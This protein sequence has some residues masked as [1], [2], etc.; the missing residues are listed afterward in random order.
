MKGSSGKLRILIKTNLVVSN[1]EAPNAFMSYLAYALGGMIFSIVAII[2]VIGPDS[3]SAASSPLIFLM[4]VLMFDYLNLQVLLTRATLIDRSMLG[5]FPLS[6][7]RSSVL[8]FILML[9]DRSILFYIIPAI[10]VVT[11]LFAK[12]EPAQAL[13][14]IL[15]FGSLYL[16]LSEILF[17]LY[18]VFRAIAERY[19]ARTA[20]QIAVLP[21][22][23][24]L[25]FPGLFQLS[26]K[27]V[28]RIP[29]AAEFV[30]GVRL[31]LVSGFDGGMLEVV[32]LLL[33]AL[34]LGGILL[35]AAFL[36]SRIDPLFHLA[37]MKR[38]L[39]RTKRPKHDREPAT[40]G[41]GKVNGSVS[42]V[43]S[44]S[45]AASRAPGL[46]RLILLD[47]QIRQKEEKFFF[48]VLINPVLAFL[49]AQV[50]APGFN[51]FLSFVILPVF[52]VTQMV[53]FLIIEN[54][55]THRGLR[56]K[57]VS[58]LPVDPARFIRI[59][60]YAEWIPIVAA[61]L[62]VTFFLGMRSGIT[63]YEGIQGIIY[64]LFIPFV[65]MLVNDS[66]VLA[67]NSLSRHAIVST[68]LILVFELVGTF[69]YALLM[70][71]N[72]AVG[73]VCVAVFCAVSYFRWMPALGKRL[74]SEF[75]TLLEESK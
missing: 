23:F 25:F 30:E 59:K 35:A 51:R 54:G 27:M 68:F 46:G 2:P 34:V 9:L 41:F 43:A 48:I 56:L 47:W 58:T 73:A 29:V 13:A 60:F 7:M 53:G 11:A 4:F 65:L 72:F 49:L 42:E 8:R 16:I 69:V 50:I 19:S 61:N 20:M 15:L 3:S 22:L 31:I 21:L 70:I 12:G 52:I 71:F 66:L 38:T 1:R 64:S 5:L 75:Q 6:G 63:Y 57:H 45:A 37:L 40:S 32:R 28:L 74:S 14:M 36:L 24:V 44:S 18:P 33:T 39:N 10:V 55:Y 26:H 17:G 67:F 62:A